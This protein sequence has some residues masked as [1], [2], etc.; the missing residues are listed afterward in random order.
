MGERKADTLTDGREIPDPE[1]DGDNGAFGEAR[2]LEEL[3]TLLRGPDW[4][5]V[6]ELRERLSDPEKYA[7]DV[8]RALP[9][10]VTLS[11]GQDQ[12]LEQSLSPIVAESFKDT[13]RRDPRTFADAIFPV[14]GPAIRKYI[15][16]ALAGIV[17]SI[18]QGLN[19]TFT[20]RGLRWRWE[21][22]RTGTSFGEIALRH[23]LVY[24]V[25]QVYLIHKE[26]SLLLEHVVAENIEA[27]SPDMVA[28][29]L[30]VIQDYFKDSF[31][32]A[33][34]ETFDALS[35]GD[36]SV[37]VEVGPE[38]ILA[39]VIRG[40]APVGLREE[41]EAA[42]EDIHATHRVPLESFDGD[43]GA[44]ATARPRLEECLHSKLAEPVARPPWFALALISVVVLL[45][46]WW[47]IPRIIESRRWHAY[48]VRLQDEP[49]VVVTQVGQRDGK[50]Y[51]AGLR[52]ALAPDPQMFLDTVGLDPERVE[53]RWDPYISLLP[54]LILRRARASLDPPAG[55]DLSLRDGVLIATGSAPTDWIDRARHVAPT[56]PGVVGFEVSDQVLSGLAAE[57]QRRSVLFA[58][59]SDTPNIPEAV[60]EIAGQV[61]A[62]DVAARARGR[63]VTVE[64]RGSTDD[65][66]DSLSNARLALARA[67]RVRAMLLAA[68]VGRAEVRAMREPLA[69]PTDPGDAV[70]ARYRRASFSI[71]LNTGSEGSP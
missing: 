3:R 39:A 41:F 10:A 33:P 23:S 9:S 29:M 64:V 37:W 38:A 48:Q 58:V 60:E 8:G 52:D 42:L 70:R 49:G 46:A 21:A 62:L 12:R 24:R 50:R 65:L 6:V 28:A 5:K 7:E 40:Q 19:N 4:D 27:Q 26:T 31:H 59:G 16:N 57:I 15:A 22:F 20:P 53:S 51:V 30:T 32:A 44:F 34:G 67:Q 11:R 17:Q 43:A 25:E 47:A 2:R 61:R 36:V 1:G 13:V 71:I 66:G 35:V 68:G 55:L 54:D 14:I 56:I 69:P 63:S 18:N 45:V